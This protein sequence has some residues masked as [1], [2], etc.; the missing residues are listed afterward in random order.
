MEAKCSLNSTLY[1]ISQNLLWCNPPRKIMQAL[2]QLVLLVFTF[3]VS[4]FLVQ[5]AF[6]LCG[7]SLTGC[8]QVFADIGTSLP[9]WPL[10]TCCLSIQNWLKTFY[11]SLVRQVWRPVIKMSCWLRLSFRW[12]YSAE[13]KV[14]RKKKVIRFCGQDPLHFGTA[15]LKR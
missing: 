9:D 10:S 3:A 5:V 6:L 15:Y 12:G 7:L 8:S 4:C 1:I 13:M 11:W 2:G 14:S